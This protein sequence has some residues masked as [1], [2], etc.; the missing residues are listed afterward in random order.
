VLLNAD[1]EILDKIRRLRDSP[2]WPSI[3][4]WLSNVAAKEV[5]GAIMGGSEQ[6]EVRCGRAQ[7][8]SE[9]VM[10]FSGSGYQ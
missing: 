3:E 2:H 6:R 1:E 9:M 5:K 10:L 7:V 4:K 8:L